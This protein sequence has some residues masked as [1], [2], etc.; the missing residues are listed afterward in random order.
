MSQALSTTERSLLQECEAVIERGVKT[1][2]E[3]GQA[4]LQIRDERL[5][6]A[7]HKTFEE[8]C[9]ERWDW[10]RSYVHRQI[11]AAQVAEN[12]LPIGNIQNEAQ[13][14]EL[15]PLPP[16]SQREVAGRAF[17]TFNGKLPS[18]RIL[19]QMVREERQRRGELPAPEPEPE[20]PPEKAAYLRDLEARMKRNSD[21]NHKVFEFI[22]A[23]EALSQPKVPIAEA[24]KYIRKNDAPDKDWCGQAKVAE[25]N[26]RQLA[27]EL[28]P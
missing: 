2:V 25:K 23:I 11:E 17:Q 13:A 14:R 5:Y 9:R 19:G 16:D 20:I 18:A 26:F 12:L 6:R 24:A 3:V 7:S 27:K 15:A 8:Y 4:L 21:Y 22:N 28:N 1:F 10:S